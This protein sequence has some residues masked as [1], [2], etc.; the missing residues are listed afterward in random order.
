MNKGKIVLEG[1]ADIIDK[2]EEKGYD[3]VEE[4]SN[5][6]IKNDKRV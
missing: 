4:K 1:G 3:W 2:L 6:E 5:E